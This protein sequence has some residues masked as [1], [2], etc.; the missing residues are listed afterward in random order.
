MGGLDGAAEEAAEGK[1]HAAAAN[2]SDSAEASAAEVALEAFRVAVAEVRTLRGQEDN[3]DVMREAKVR[4]ATA[5]QAATAAGVSQAELLE[6]SAAPAAEEAAAEAA[7]E[8]EEER[9]G[10]KCGDRVEI[11]GLESESGKQ[12]N[13]KVGTISSYLEDKGR[14]QIELGPDKFVSVRL[15][16][17]QKRPQT[18][19]EE[20]AGGNE[21][22]PNGIKCGDRVEVSGLESESGMKLNGKVGI[23]KEY[24]A[25]K[26]RCK[27]E[28]SPAECISVKPAN[29]TRRSPLPGKRARSASSSASS[30]SS[31]AKRPKEKAVPKVPKNLS[32]EEAM[33]FL[34]KGG[35]KSKKRK[36]SGGFQDAEEVARE[37]AR[38]PD[39]STAAPPP[40]PFA[41]SAAPP[42]PAAPRPAAPRPAAPAVLRPGDRVEVFGL[43]S[44]AGK[45]LNGKTGLITKFVE[46]K[47]R[48]Q[49]ELGLATLQS[50]K[51]ENLRQC[52]SSA[53]SD[54]DPFGCQLGSDYT[55][56]SAGYTLL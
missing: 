37:A 2:K 44:A 11:V 14:F 18:P 54:G 4:L 46:E 5:L 13:G 49:V 25:D 31:S 27:I 24:M 39:F 28:L 52:S 20:A 16:N 36:R 30:S 21:A 17:L 35:K 50:L 32:P 26:G 22:I 6:A 56:A 19:G 51:P 40:S 7:E 34:L 9:E 3:E 29:L 10:L 43:L 15:V 42:R 8:A 45:P 53:Q 41:P 48:F 55:G 1:E 33:E 23:V 12:L 38:Q 47:G